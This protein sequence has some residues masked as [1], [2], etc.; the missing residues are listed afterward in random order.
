MCTDHA[1]TCKT[2]GS[3]PWPWP[4]WSQSPTPSEHVGLRV[5]PDR[6]PQCHAVALG[7]AHSAY[8]GF[9]TA[10][11]LRALNARRGTPKRASFVRGH[12]AGLMLAEHTSGALFTISA[13]ERSPEPPKDRWTPSSLSRPTET[14]RQRLVHYG[15]QVF[16]SLATVFKANRKAYR[17]PPKQNPCIVSVLLSLCYIQTHFKPP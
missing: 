7:G 14:C 15:F 4:W 2:E 10:G 11:T 8:T 5:S 3:A 12:T 17:K 16:V 1:D 6:G 13:T 9:F